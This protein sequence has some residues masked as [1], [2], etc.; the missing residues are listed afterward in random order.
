MQ[1]KGIVY[2]MSSPNRNSLYVGVTSDLPVRVWK[3]KTKCFPKSFSARYNCVMLVYYQEFANMT[4]AVAEEKRLKSGGK[5]QKELLI[6][7]FN[8]DWVDLSDSIM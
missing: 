2:I 3:H 5:A 4:D 1:K 8:P 6:I 7:Q